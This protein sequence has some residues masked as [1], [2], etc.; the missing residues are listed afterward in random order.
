MSKDEPIKVSLEMVAAGE[1]IFRQRVSE[2][3]RGFAPSKAVC[4][5][6]AIAIYVAMSQARAHKEE[7]S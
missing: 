3:Y 7:A 5:A 2:N 1:G 6:A 4:E